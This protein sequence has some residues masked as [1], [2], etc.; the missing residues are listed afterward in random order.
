MF[1]NGTHRQGN[2]E[3]CTFTRTPFSRKKYLRRA[4]AKLDGRFQ[5]DK[6]LVTRTAKAE[7]LMLVLNSFTNWF[8]YTID[9]C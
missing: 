9:S 4:D 8:C 6:K 5:A 1:V 7:I 2:T 3:K